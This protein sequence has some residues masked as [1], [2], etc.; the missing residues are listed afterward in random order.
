MFSIDRD[1]TL[2][3]RRELL[4]GVAVGSVACAIG[5]GSSS[6]VVALGSTK[7]R[8]LINGFD[9]FRRQT[10]AFINFFKVFR[11]QAA[12]YR[13]LSP[14]ANINV[15]GYPLGALE[16]DYGSAIKCEGEPFLA[17]D[18]VW[19]LKWRG[20]GGGV[21]DNGGAGF[22]VTSDPGHFTT[23][24]ESRL[25]QCS[26]NMMDGSNRIEFTNEAG[27]MRLGWLFS[28]SVPYDGSMKDLQLYRKTDEA[29]FNAGAIFT[30]EFL[31]L[32]RTLN[33]KIIRTMDWS[34]TNGNNIASFR[35]RCPVT[36]FSYLT[37]KWWTSG[38]TALWC[39][40][41]AGAGQYSCPNPKASSSNRYE[42]GETVQLC[43]DNT[44][45]VSPPTLNISGR[46]AVPIANLSNAEIEVGKIRPNTP[47]TLIYDSFLEVWILTA[48]NAADP[49]GGLT[50][51]VPIEIQ[52]ALC[53][54]LDV[55]FWFNIP[56]LYTDESITAIASYIRENLSPNLSAYFELSNECWNEI[57][58]Q[59]RLCRS[60]GKALG[61]PTKHGRAEYGYYGLRVC[62][63]MSLVTEAWAPRSVATLRRVMAVQETGA[64][65]TVKHFQLDGADLSTA[66]GDHDHIA[67]TRTNESKGSRKYCRPIN[68]CDVLSYALYF[69]GALIN[70]GTM[71]RNFSKFDIH[72]VMRA[73]DDFASGVERRIASALAFV[74]DD[75][76]CGVYQATAVIDMAMG[77]VRIGPHSFE[78]G[79]VVTFAVMEDGS[80]PEGMS[81]VGPY[82][83]VARTKDAIRLA[84]TPG[85]W[86]LKFSGGSRLL[87]GLVGPATL[88][89]HS[90]F[91]FGDSL[92]GRWELI[93]A[94]Y[95][96]ARPEGSSALDVECYEGG[97][98]SEAPTVAQCEAIGLPLHYGGVGGLI[99]NMLNGYKNSTF[100]HQL[101]IDAFSQFLSFRHSKTPAWFELQGP[102]R[103]SL[104]PGS[105]FTQPY[106]TFYGNAA[107]NR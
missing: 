96:D 45:S 66:F 39:G 3:T 32:L 16:N 26:G 105:T 22:V 94:G 20:N 92:V 72:R 6:S 24:S 7:A 61:I 103:W 19:V 34:R 75:I 23:K 65:A 95:D 59:T 81:R 21:L 51:G 12:P 46:G 42:H 99:E 79:D 30:P 57:F 100:A 73:A 84:N 53:N 74:D 8:S 90:D 91:L 44:N 87:I 41:A 70:D 55:N 11:N 52:V 62:Q 40:F 64:P 78:N 76:R 97:L 54:E 102:S 86:P 48:E 80:L 36:A 5:L 69:N 25:L 104:Q 13:Q 58:S 71:Y 31:L 4:A 9:L 67:P 10:F 14:E 50:S 98:Q 60:R 18:V 106:Q 88:Q 38:V 35:N 107:F 83:V 82:F 2:I 77:K 101:V 15:D 63:A 17:P 28:S 37:E 89:S 33:P 68:V 56:I 27:A 47:C 29:A 93:A 85:G 49:Y 1:S 43:F